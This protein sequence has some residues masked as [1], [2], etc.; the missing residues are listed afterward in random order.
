MKTTMYMTAVLA[1]T[2]ASAGCATKRYVRNKIAPVQQQV[3]AADAK[4]VEQDEEIR[5]QSTQIEALDRGLSSTRERLGDTDAKLNATANTALQANDAAAQANRNALA[6]QQSAD[7]A[8]SQNDKLAREVERMVTYKTTAF[9]VVLFAPGQQTLN[10]DAQAALDDF[11]KATGSQARFVIEVQGF[12]DKTGSPA[13]NDILSQRRAEAVARY[14]ATAHNIPLRN[15]TLLGTGV[16][17]GDQNT[18]D[19]RQQSR[20]VEFRLLLPEKESVT[21]AR[22]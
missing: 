14:L 3:T 19:E 20:R 15:M 1:L 6:A 9:G 11:V 16:A 8:I 10:A 4:N 7:G 18:A 22:N 5:T 13:M 12:T 17:P 21:A 2:L